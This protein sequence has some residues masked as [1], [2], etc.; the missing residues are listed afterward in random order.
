MAT[1]ESDELQAYLDEA[2]GVRPLSDWIWG[3]SRWGKGVLVRAGLA[4]AGA[5]VDRWRQ[6]APRDEGWQRHFASSTQPEEALSALRAW[7]ARGAPPGDA[8]L[9]SCTAALRDLIGNAEFYDDEASSWGAASE[10]EQAA[11]SGRAILMALE[12]SQWTA[13]RATEDI[14]DEAERQAIARSGPVPELW[15]AVRAYRHAL[16]D[17]SEATVRELIRNGLR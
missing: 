8:G 1:G 16:P 13:E 17:C 11:A 14:P 5:C 6:G 9:A 12:A 15:E 4:I 7:L 10:R 2:P 3:L